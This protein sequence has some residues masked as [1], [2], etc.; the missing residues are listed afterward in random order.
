MGENWEKEKVNLTWVRCKR[1][2]ANKKLNAALYGSQHNN[3]FCICNT[4]FMLIYEYFN[5]LI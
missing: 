4:E 2:W 3:R 5:F 1:I